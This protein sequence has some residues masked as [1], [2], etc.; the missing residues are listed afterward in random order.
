MK[1][2]IIMT[3]FVKKTL[4]K[5]YSHLVERLLVKAQIIEAAEKN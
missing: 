5:A 2:N 3:S 4:K 1:C